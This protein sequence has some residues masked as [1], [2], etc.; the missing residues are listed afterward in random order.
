MILVITPPHPADQEVNIAN[1]LLDNGLDLLHIR[2]YGLPDEELISYVRQI[3]TEQHHK[4]VLHSHRH[5]AGRLGIKRI[6]FNEAD[7]RSLAHEPINEDYLISTSVHHIDD[8]NLLS[9]YWEYAFLSPLYQ[10]IS[11]PEK[12]RNEEVFQ[13]LKKRNN[14]QVKLVGLGGIALENIENTLNQ[15]VDAIAL[16][17]A[18]WLAEHPIEAFLKC[19]NLLAQLK[20]SKSNE[21]IQ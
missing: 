1:E 5:L 7:R 17:G 14:H 10:S 9:A 3:S 19:K 20:K 8:F 6:H 12:S 4:L 16:L 11:K 13:Q 21:I 15:P 2:K 18:I